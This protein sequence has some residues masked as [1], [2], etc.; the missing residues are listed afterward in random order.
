M[1]Y[2]TFVGAKKLLQEHGGKRIQKSV[3]GFLKGLRHQIGRPEIH[4]AIAELDSQIEAHPD[5]VDLYFQRA[6][7]KFLDL[8]FVEALQD[9]Y[10]VFNANQNNLSALMLKAKIVMFMD[11]FETAEAILESA[12]AVAPE[13]APL[14]AQG[15]PTG[16][17]HQDVLMSML[18]NK[19]NQITTSDPFKSAETVAMIKKAKET[20]QRIPEPQVDESDSED[21]HRWHWM[22]A[23][24]HFFA[25]CQDES[26]SAELKAAIEHLDTAWKIKEHAEMASMIA[27][28]HRLNGNEKLAQE[29]SDVAKQL[30]PEVFLADATDRSAMLIPWPVQ[31]ILP[32]GAIVHDAH[33]FQPKKFMSPTYCDGCNKFIHGSWFRTDAQCGVCGV[34]V[35]AECQQTIERKCV[36]DQSRSP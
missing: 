7:A 29:F 21:A 26:Q 32:D 33:Q 17:D 23:I 18:S 10:P 27:Q 9:L 30:D 35:H 8:Q 4:K 28:C 3:K 36:E 22:S 25:Y 16:F 6:S 19:I 2:F 12:L 14:N 24:C 34:G 5:Q 15:Q 20:L 13:K 1:G 11:Q 31:K